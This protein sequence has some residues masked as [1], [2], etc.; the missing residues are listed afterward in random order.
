MARFWDKLNQPFPEEGS[1][2][3]S[4][5]SLIGVSI[6]V[7]MFLYLLRPFGLGERTDLPAICLGFGLVTLGACLLHDLVV[8]RIIKLRT[9]LPSWTL[10]RWILNMLSVI[11]FIALG[12]FIF[13]NWWSD[14]IGLDFPSLLQTLFNTA[15]VGVIPI[16]FIGLIIQNRETKKHVLE[17]RKISIS[18]STSKEDESVLIDGI[19]YSIRDLRFIEAQQNYVSIHFVD[20][21]AIKQK[22][23]RMTFRK[24]EEIFTGSSIVRCHRS[25]F[26]NKNAVVHIDGNAQGLKLTLKDLSEK[27][28]PVSKSYTKD[29]K[30]ALIRP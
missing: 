25:F 1:I 23:V 27:S 26:V 9:D 18:A 24:L 6:F 21:G 22:L 15:L 17:A 7:G 11:L 28:I 10:G 30:S 16:V 13:M 12:N 14:W 19:N 8:R 29:I 5:K 20:Q 4:L 3:Q 2:E